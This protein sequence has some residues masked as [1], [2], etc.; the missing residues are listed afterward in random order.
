MHGNGKSWSESKGEKEWVKNG[1]Y[2]TKGNNN[3]SKWRF[4]NQIFFGP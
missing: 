1:R 4:V 3:I 2:A